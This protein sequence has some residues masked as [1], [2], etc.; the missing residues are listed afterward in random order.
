MNEK[1][2]ALLVDCDNTSLVRGNA[3]ETSR[4]VPGPTLALRTD[5]LV[6]SPQ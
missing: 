1:K 3:P 2:A 4:G 6:D 5:R